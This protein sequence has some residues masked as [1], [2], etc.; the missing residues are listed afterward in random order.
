MRMIVVDSGS[1]GNGYI[2][3]SST[4]ECLIIDA[5][6]SF[7]ATMKHIGFDRFLS[8]SGLIVSHRHQD[9]AKY[10][11]E[12]A[13]YGVQCYVNSD[14]IKHLKFSKN[15]AVAEAQKRKMTETFDQ[16][17]FSVGSFKVKP[18]EVSHEVQC[19]S[20][21]ISHPEMGVTYFITDS[22][23]CQWDLTGAGVNNW[24]VECNYDMDL[25]NA[26]YDAGLLPENVRT[27]VIAGHF[28]LHNCRDF[29]RINKGAKTNKVVL[30]HTSSD[31]GN[32]KKFK[33]EI[34]AIIG[35]SVSIAKKGLVIENFNR[36]AF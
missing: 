22:N 13:N 16:L 24:M 33:S 36:R 15:A 6:C 17:Q 10:L 20:F 1:D 14:T 28:G 9:H 30:L 11:A 4:G 35:K 8:V 19:F 23:Y 26:R 3:E 5:G 32:R 27:H 29:F 21:L 25:L 2:L 18:L 7:E 34:E 12:F 31:H